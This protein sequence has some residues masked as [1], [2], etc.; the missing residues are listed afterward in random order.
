MG[1]VVE[2]GKVKK[3]MG[4]DAD[5]AL[6]EKALTAVSYPK[7]RLIVLRLGLGKEEKHT[8]AEL[9]KLF[10][11]TPGQIHKRFYQACTDVR[12][13]F[14]LAEKGKKL[15]VK[16]DPYAEGVLA[17]YRLL[18]LDANKLKQLFEQKGLTIRMAAEALGSSVSAVNKWLSGNQ[19]V[20]K[21]SI[22]QLSYL[23][24]VD[25]AELLYKPTKKQ[26]EAMSNEKPKPTVDMRYLDLPS[27]WKELRAL[28]QDFESK[29]GWV[30]RNKDTLSIEPKEVKT[31]KSQ[32]LTEEERD[33]PLYELE[34]STRA[35]NSLDRMS[36]YYLGD[37]L[38]WTPN[39]LLTTVR[40]LGERTLKEIQSILAEEGYALADE[41]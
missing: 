4:Y 20:K 39:E 32:V 2:S 37:L 40:H 41:Q 15:E 10:D 36:I 12:R 25:P 23:L 19:S 24:Q 8:L 28:L 3:I 14:Y 16:C 1:R 18:T 38:K 11:T 29:T 9:A 30:V 35:L 5:F 31:I 34:F 22:Y 13:Q 21:Q 6:V 7:S 26:I 17:D 33:R 27:Q